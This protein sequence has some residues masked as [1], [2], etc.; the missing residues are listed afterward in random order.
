MQKPR[1]QRAVA[2]L[3]LVSGAA[4][5]AEVKW[6]QA[7]PC[8]TPEL[9]GSLGRRTS[10][11]PGSLPPEHSQ[12]QWLLSVPTLSSWTS[13]APGNQ[14]HTGV[15][16]ARGGQRWMGLS[17]E[18]GVDHLGKTSACT[19]GRWEKGVGKTAEPSVGQR[20]RCRDPRLHSNAWMGG[21]MGR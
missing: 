13:N 14:V 20:N 9:L 15:S 7:S 2:P 18:C 4:A 8:P 6:S 21:E 1:I 17:A 12:G 11:G 10:Q 5:A 3:C 16:G 19:R